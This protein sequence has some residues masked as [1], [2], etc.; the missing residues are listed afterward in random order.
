MLLDLGKSE[1][2]PVVEG[3]EIL[4]EEDVMVVGGRGECRDEDCHSADER[5]QLHTVFSGLIQTVEPV[6][7]EPWP[8]VQ[9]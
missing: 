6:Q 7:V 1:G 2:L 4:A 9:P 3:G 8:A 5:E